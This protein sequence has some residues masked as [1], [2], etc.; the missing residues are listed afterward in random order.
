MRSFQTLRLN[1]NPVQDEGIADIGTGFRDI[2]CL[3]QLSMNRVVDL[4]LPSSFVCP[5]PVGSQGQHLGQWTSLL[6]LNFAENKL[7]NDGFSY[8]MTRLQHVSTPQALQL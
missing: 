2:P 5:A 6:R 3:Q 1:N 8:L 7:G 4:K